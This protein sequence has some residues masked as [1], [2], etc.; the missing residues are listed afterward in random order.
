MQAT[1]AHICILTQ[2]EAGEY[3]AADPE[4]LP[5]RLK[6]AA[7]VLEEKVEGVTGQLAEARYAEQKACFGDCNSYSKTDPDATFMRVNEDHMKNGQLKPGYNVNGHG[8]PIHFV[9]QPPS[10]THGDALLHPA[11]GAIGRDFFA[12]M[13]AMAVKKII[14]IRWAKKT[15]RALIFSF[16]TATAGRSKLGGTSRTSSMHPTGRMKSGMAVLFAQMAGTF[17]LRVLD[18]KN[19]IWFRAKLQDL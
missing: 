7:V 5:A 13:R 12:P 19:G 18:P 11:Y 6:E 8:K 2:Q 9:L 14:C 15:R 16:L 17:V 3:A 1:L 10:A 4:E